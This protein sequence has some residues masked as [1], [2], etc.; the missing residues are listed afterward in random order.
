MMFSWILPGTQA[1]HAKLLALDC[2]TGIP[3]VRLQC[4]GVV[5]C[6]SSHRALAQCWH[7][8]LSARCTLTPALFLEVTKDGRSHSRSTRTSPSCCPS[9]QTCPDLFPALPFPM[10]I[11]LPM[12]LCLARSLLSLCSHTSDEDTQPF[13]NRTISPVWCILYDP[14]IPDTGG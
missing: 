3:A 7:L 11:P 10:G 9:S 5:T 6:F 2:A 1:R 14:G 4:C 13:L 8:L 12:C